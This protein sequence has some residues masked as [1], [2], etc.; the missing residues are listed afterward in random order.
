MMKKKL[1]GHFCWG[2]AAIAAYWLGGVGGSSSSPESSLSD[3]SATGELG[4]RSALSPDARMRISQSEQDTRATRGEN[5]QT[6]SGFSTSGATWETLATQAMRDQNPIKRRLAF[7][8]LLQSLTPENA[9]DIREQ[10]VSLGTK[11]DEWRDFNYAWGALAGEEAFLFAASSEED[12]MSAAVAGWASANPG[13][14]IAMLDNLPEDMKGQRARLAESVVQGLSDSDR[15]AATE[16]VLRLASE[17][18]AESGKLMT[19]VANDA[20][21]VDGVEGAARWLDS[22][23]DNPVKG[24]AMQRIAGAYVERDAEAAA[25]WVEAVADQDYATSGLNS[26]FGDW[27]DR[28]P[29]AATEYLSKMPESTQRDA[30]ISGLSRG[31]AWQDPEAAIAW[32]HEISEPT[33]RQESLTRAGQIFFRRDPT[34][35][36]AW[37][38]ESELPLKTQEAIL[39][40]RG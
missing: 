8:K 32:A 37:L 9:L 33:L 6:A 4:S 20:L 39:N 12:D 16:L 38:Q 11:G 28:D 30:A 17:G 3:G 24:A 10:L 40:T 14:A 13:E 19:L 18:M 21:R 29:L 2:V 36:A 26:A 27:E 22:L 31:Y 23:P 7:S 25:R 5:S 35:A 34:S 1:I 15:G